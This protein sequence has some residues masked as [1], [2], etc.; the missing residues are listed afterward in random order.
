[1]HDFAEVEGEVA[2]HFCRRDDLK[3]GCS[4]T[5]AGAC[6]VSE[7]ATRLLQAPR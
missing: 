7:R 4:A 3:R 5:G 6:G 1:M 2:Y